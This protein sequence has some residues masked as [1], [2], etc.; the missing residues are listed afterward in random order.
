MK[1]QSKMVKQEMQ[2][3]LRRIEGQVRGVQRMLD[4]DREC[5]EIVQQL[6]AIRAAVQNATAVFMQAYAKECLLDTDNLTELER[7]DLVDELMSL[8]VKTV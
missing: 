2:T 5:R 4:E 6:V 7:S 3:R 1:L 8:L